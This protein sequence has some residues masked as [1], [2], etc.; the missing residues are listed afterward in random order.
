MLKK[1]FLFYGDAETLD[2]RLKRG[3]ISPF[4][5]PSGLHSTPEEA[6]KKI[7]KYSPDTDEVLVLSIY[8]CCKIKRTVE[9][10]DC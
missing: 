4:L 7:D 10:E 5:N 6:L 2:M 1:Y 8:R 3:H 9:F